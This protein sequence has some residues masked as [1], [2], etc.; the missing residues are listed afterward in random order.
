MNATHATSPH[1]VRVIVVDDQEWIR[2]IAA[3][4]VRQTLP[5]AQ[6]IVATDGLEALMAFRQGGADFVVTNHHMPRMDG[7]ILIGELRHLA[8]DLPIVMISV[9]P[10]AQADAEAAG[11]NWFLQK[12][13]IM[14]LLPALLLD[15]LRERTGPVFEEQ[16]GAA[17]ARH[18]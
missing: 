6:L 5:N 9:H 3:Q 10:E 14:E 4:V 11:A 7:A 16:R 12:D 1:A 2:E 18:T 8:P 17:V 15:A 13:Q